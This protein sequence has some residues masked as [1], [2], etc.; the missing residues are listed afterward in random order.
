MNGRIVEVKRFAVHDGPGI[1]TTLF[2]KGCPLRCRWC[3]NPESI[4]PEPEIGFLERKCIGCARCAEVCPAGVHSFRGGTHVLDRSRCTACGKCVEACLPGALEYYG[5][6]MTVEEAVRAVLE[7]KNF[8]L[9][10]GG[11]C[12][13]SGGEPL[14]QPEFCA[15]VFQRLRDGGVHCAIDTS[16]AV[17]WHAFE[18]VLPH[19]DMVLYD[20]KHTDGRR[21]REH[22]GSPSR[23]IVSNLERLSQRG[24]PIEVRIPVIPGFNTDAE[25]LGAIGG[26]L[27]RLPNVSGVRLLAYHALARSKYQTVGRPDTMP[28]VPAPPPQQMHAIAARLAEFGLHV[29]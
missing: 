3:H 14:V 8:Y 13:M 5:R 16:G 22:T 26:W 23:L 18:V 29:T 28:D 21:H 4:S 24:I 15:E 1:R 6:G 2:L 11:G 12:T 19:T 10:S 7:D 17:E 27:S 9:H 20:V 25:S